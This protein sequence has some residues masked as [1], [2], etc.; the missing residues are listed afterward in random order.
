MKQQQV[1]SEQCALLITDSTRLV[2][3]NILIAYSNILS[4]FCVQGKDFY[5][6]CPSHYTCDV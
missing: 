6:F 3:Y 1:D 5:Y 4:L 2:C